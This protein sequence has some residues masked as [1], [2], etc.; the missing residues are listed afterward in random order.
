MAE[1]KLHKTDLIDI[2]TIF[3]D[4]ADFNCRREKITPAS[5]EVIMEDMKARGLD[6]PVHVYPFPK[7]HPSGK[8]YKLLAGYRRTHAAIW[9]GWTKVPAFIRNDIAADVDQRAFNIRENLQRKNLTIVDEAYAIQPYVKM[10]ASSKWIAEQIG[11]SK[12]WVEERITIGRLPDC[13]QDEIAKHPTWFK[14]GHIERMVDMPL[15]KQMEYVH[16]IKTHAAN[17]ENLPVRGKNPTKGTD[18]RKRTYEEMMS[19]GNAIYD[20]F[21][22]GIETRLLAWARGDITN[23]AILEDLNVVAIDRN[24]VFIPPEDISAL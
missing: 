11:M 5:V 9:L 8:K 7:E 24:R 18:K 22:P 10:Q 1:P 3:I 4:D 16:Q 21:G 13:I 19:L 15:Q 14:R 23:Y 6:Q 20:A 17:G 2:D 12:R